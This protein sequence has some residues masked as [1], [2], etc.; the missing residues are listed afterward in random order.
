MTS[1]CFSSKIAITLCVHN[2][3][4]ILFNSNRSFIY[5]TQKKLSL[6]VTQQS[7]IIM[8]RNIIYMLNILQ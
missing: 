1:I 2:K 7:N 8:A 4:K 6:S 3:H 5:Y